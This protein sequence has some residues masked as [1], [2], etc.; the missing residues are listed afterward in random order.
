MRLYIESKIITHFRISELLRDLLFISLIS[1]R[2]FLLLDLWWLWNNFSL[3]NW[4]DLFSFTIFLYHRVFSLKLL[5]HLPCGFS[6]NLVKLGWNINLTWWTILLSLWD[7]LKIFPNTRIGIELI[8][9]F[10]WKR[11]IWC[12][13]QEFLGSFTCYLLCKSCFL[14]NS[15]KATTNYSI[16]WL[17]LIRVSIRILTAGSVIIIS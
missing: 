5:D 4:L 12:L 14:L 15:Y 7:N 1:S 3:V 13:Y 2:F 16:K 8:A 9:Y 17:T 6:V 10:W 11:I